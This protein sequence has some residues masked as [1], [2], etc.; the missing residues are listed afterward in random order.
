[1]IRPETQTSNRFRCV[2]TGTHPESHIEKPES[3]ELCNTNKQIQTLSRSCDVKSMA[4]TNTQV[5]KFIDI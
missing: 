5:L 4:L 3:I 2:K 1:M